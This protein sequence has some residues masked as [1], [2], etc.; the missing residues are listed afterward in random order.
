[1][2]GSPADQ[3]GNGRGGLGLVDQHMVPTRRLGRY[4]AR[5]PWGRRA[6]IGNSVKRCTHVCPIQ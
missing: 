1:M 5:H 2:S 3:L 6:W 4:V